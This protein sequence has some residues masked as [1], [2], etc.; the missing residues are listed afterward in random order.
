M[1]MADTYT[2]YYTSASVL[3][4]RFAIVDL[5]M[6]RE[7]HLQE[8]SKSLCKRLLSGIAGENYETSTRS[9]HST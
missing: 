8:V 7:L 1:I 3:S 9:Y 6:Q 4:S 2:M 5:S